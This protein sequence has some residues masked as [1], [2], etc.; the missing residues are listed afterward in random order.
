MAAEQQVH[1]LDIRHRRA[2][3]SAAYRETELE[4]LVE[5]R[6]RERSEAFIRAM[7]A[8]GFR[9]QSVEPE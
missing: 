7:S 8:Q 4:L 1:I 2:F 3:T 6:G 9:A 5:T